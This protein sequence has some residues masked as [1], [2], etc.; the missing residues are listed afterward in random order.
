MVTPRSAASTRNEGSRV[1]GAGRPVRTASRR[2]SGRVTFGPRLQER[3]AQ[4]L[5]GI[6]DT[7]GR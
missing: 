6:A 2:A 7:L 3:A 5:R 4:A 1:P